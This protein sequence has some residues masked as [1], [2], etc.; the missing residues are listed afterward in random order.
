M[1]KT[2]LLIF[3]CLITTILLVFITG[4]I[5]FAV[6]YNRR[7]NDYEKEKIITHKQHIQDLLNTKIKIQ[8]QT[9]IDM[10]MEIHDGIVQHLALASILS[11]QLAE[12]RVY[13]QI[14]ESIETIA[15]TLNNTIEEVRNLSHSLSNPDEKIKTLK[16]L[17][18]DEC[19]QVRNLRVCNVEYNC[20]RDK[21]N[22]PTSTKNFILRIVQEFLQ[23]SLKHSE[24]KNI[25]LLLE[26]NDD[27]LIL[28]VSDDG[29]GFDMEEYILTRTKKIGIINMKKRAE[30]IDA[31]ITVDT[32]KNKGTS[33]HLQLPNGK[34]TNLREEYET[35]QNSNS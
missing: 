22:I 26:Y 10:G 33:L 24:C 23:N 15:F 1:G 18:D 28:K 20:A 4:F 25:K 35:I 16:E 17:V 29:V 21:T 34:L 7:K 13:P 2:E 27:G 11:N 30:L 19:R 5:V 12:S 6:F 31:Q 8:A 9:M 32:E 14:Q 3:F